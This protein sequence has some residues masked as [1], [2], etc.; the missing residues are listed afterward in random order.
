MLDHQRNTHNMT[1][2]FSSPIDVLRAAANG[3]TFDDERARSDIKAAVDGYCA[4]AVYT[5][6]HKDQKRSR[7]A[8]KALEPLLRHL[9][10]LGERLDSMTGETWRDWRWT[11]A[12]AYSELPDVREELN[13]WNAALAEDFADTD[14]DLCDYVKTEVDQVGRDLAELSWQPAKPAPW[15]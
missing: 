7:D 12:D 15:S 2:N 4:A 3:E 11:A 8:E 5:S 1:K 13:R 9:H 6:I 14:V 10:K